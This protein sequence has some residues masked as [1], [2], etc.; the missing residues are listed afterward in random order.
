MEGGM[1][2]RLRIEV[3]WALDRLIGRGNE[4][5]RI[6]SG[7]DDQTRFVELEVQHTG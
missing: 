5:Q 6:F 3:E 4:R 2:R 7:G 1:A